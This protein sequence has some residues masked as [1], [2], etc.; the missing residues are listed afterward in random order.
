MEEI[1]EMIRSVK[2]VVKEELKVICS[3]KHKDEA[4]M[5]LCNQMKKPAINVRS[6]LQASAVPFIPSSLLPPLVPKP[7]GSMS[8]SARRS[9]R[10]SVRN[11]PNKINK[12]TRKNANKN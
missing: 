8:R 11:S 2:N 7:M 4:I 5:I 1:H 6:M 9:M 3:G 10:Q 12:N